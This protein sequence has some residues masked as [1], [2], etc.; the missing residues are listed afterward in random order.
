MTKLTTPQKD[1]L[2][3]LQNGHYMSY[4]HNLHNY[5]DIALSG[6]GEKVSWRTA[7]ALN[8][9][10]FTECTVE[11]KNEAIYEITAAGKEVQL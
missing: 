6:T 3:K 11:D 10:H 9:R 8:L 1:L 7:M 5:N 4:S 2:K